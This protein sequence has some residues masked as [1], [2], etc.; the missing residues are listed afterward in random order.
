MIHAGKIVTHRALITAV[1][2]AGYGDDTR[3]LRVFMVQLRRKI[4]PD[5]S[6]PTYILTEPGI[7]YRFRG[8]P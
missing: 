2:G 4:E 1:W 7:G 3:N 8:E 6:Y 5:P